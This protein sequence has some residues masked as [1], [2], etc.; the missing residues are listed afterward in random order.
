MGDE[1]AVSSDRNLVIKRTGSLS[2]QAAGTFISGHINQSLP[3][4][5]IYAKLIINDAFSNF[6]LSKKQQV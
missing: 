6:P 1:N 2:L 4:L 5:K 3:A